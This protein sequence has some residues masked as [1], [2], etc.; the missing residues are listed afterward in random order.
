MHTN[1]EVNDVYIYT[2]MH[3]CVFILVCLFFIYFNVCKPAGKLPSC[4]LFL[5]YFFYVCN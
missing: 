3:V 4:L 1:M 2:S 5:L